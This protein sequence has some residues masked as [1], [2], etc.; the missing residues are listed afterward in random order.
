M[1]FSSVARIVVEILDLQDMVVVFVSSYLYRVQ[2]NTTEFCAAGV[3]CVASPTGEIVPSPSSDDTEQWTDP[4]RGATG[5]SN[6]KNQSVLATPTAPS[7]VV[8]IEGY[9]KVD[10]FISNSVQ[11][12]GSSVSS[13]ASIKSTD[14]LLHLANGKAH[15]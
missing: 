10:E 11:A 9:G 8:D 13:E 4:L 12:C 14:N 1:C 3:G 6:I 5:T 2:E 15:H 7:I